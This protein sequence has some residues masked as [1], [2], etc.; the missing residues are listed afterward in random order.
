MV[1]WRAY[2]RAAPIARATRRLRSST[3]PV[4][5]S[6]K[7]GSPDRPMT[8]VPSGLPPAISRYARA[9]PWV[10]CGPSASAGQG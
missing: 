9:A 5:S 4:T 6:G 10:P 2:W 8:S 7:R 3:R 1:A